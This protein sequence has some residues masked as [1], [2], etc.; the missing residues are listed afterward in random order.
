MIT[1]CLDEDWDILDKSVP[2]I[3]QKELQFEKELHDFL[4][5]FIDKEELLKEEFISKNVA[6]QH[7]KKH[8][9]CGIPTRKST[10]H[11]IYY[12]FDNI[13]KYK[14]YEDKINKLV[15]ETILTINYLGNTNIIN[16]YFHKLFTGNQCIYFTTSCGFTNNRGAVN[17]GIHAFSTGVTTN[18]SSANTVDFLILSGGKTI[19]MYP[20]DAHYLQTKLNNIIKQYTNTNFSLSFNRD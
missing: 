15:T 7:Y 10:K 11:N 19:T 17:I 13:G 16:K 20:I 6:Q 3:T 14:N 2:P 5:S 8:C 1:R 12:D 18:Y 9:L 4:Q